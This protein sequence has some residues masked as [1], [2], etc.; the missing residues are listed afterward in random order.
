MSSPETN[1]VHSW[2]PN[3]DKG[4][5]AEKGYS[6]QEIVLSQLISGEK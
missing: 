3:Y 5:A 1:H 2:S 4:D 6:F